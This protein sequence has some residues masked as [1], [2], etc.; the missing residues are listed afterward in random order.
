MAIPNR[1]LRPVSSELRYLDF[2]QRAFCKAHKQRCMVN[3]PH[4]LLL[5]NSQA[6]RVYDACDQMTSRPSPLVLG[7]A[8]RRVELSGFV[9]TETFRPPGLELPTHFHENTNIALTLD[10]TFAETIRGR[11]Q[12]VDPSGI[13]L[14]PAGEKHSN[15][16]GRV[17]SR[18]LIIEVMPQ[19]LAMI[20]EVTSILDCAAYFKGESSASFGLRI[21]REF[22]SM[23]CLAPLSIEALVLEMLVEITREDSRLER[24]QSRW[25]RMAGDL[26]HDQFSQTLSLS[27]IAEVVG[28][29]PA[30]LAKMFRRHYGC[31]IGEYIRILRLD[32]AAKLLARPDKTLSDIALAAG[33]YDQSHFAHLFRLRFG[34]TPGGSRAGLRRKQLPVVPR[35]QDTLPG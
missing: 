1:F 2:C 4:P 33:F 5:L 6:R 10:G 7:N 18:S 35:K 3:S 34:V 14:R 25:L 24:D 28:V 32:Y 13:V 19:R 15:Q 20:S 22:K 26:V 17:G 9:L 30:H 27:N 8:D 11:A 23:D 21:Y 29:H 31:T 12:Q 16:Y